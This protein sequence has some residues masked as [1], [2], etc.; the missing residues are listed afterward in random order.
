MDKK[1][2]R[3][4]RKKRVRKTV[5]GTS[6][7]PRLSV[8]RSNK[9]LYVQIIDDDKGVTLAS[10]STHSLAK[11]AEGMK[12]TEVA[13][14]LGVE[15]AKIAVKK[16]ITKVAFD[17]SGYRYHGKVKEIAVGAREGGLEF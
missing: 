7:R 10:C 1:E 16:K 8:F 12:G 15:I 2:K 17:R 11:K 6:D 4:K 5:F 9:N 13:K 14:M 3:L